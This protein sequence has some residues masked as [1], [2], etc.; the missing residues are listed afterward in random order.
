MCYNHYASFIF[1]SNLFCRVSCEESTK[2]QFLIMTGG[3]QYNIV[4]IGCWCEKTIALSFS[5]KSLALISKGF[6]TTIKTHLYTVHLHYYYYCLT[7]ITRYRLENNFQWCIWCTNEY[8][9]MFI[10]IKEGATT[11]VVTQF[12]LFYTILHAP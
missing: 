8:L 10:I 4:Y 11:R 1:L 9:N 5:T 3:W 12:H 6:V 7:S 2:Y